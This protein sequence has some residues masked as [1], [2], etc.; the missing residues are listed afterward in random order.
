[1]T[2]IWEVWNWFDWSE[3]FGDYVKTI[4]KLEVAL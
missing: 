3:L 2:D 1:M 4:Y